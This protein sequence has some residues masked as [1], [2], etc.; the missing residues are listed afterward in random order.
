MAASDVIHN[1][2]ADDVVCSGRAHEEV[3]N[4]FQFSH[5]GFSGVRLNGFSRKP[6]Y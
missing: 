1:M 5:H 6:N 4:S 2:A 3:T